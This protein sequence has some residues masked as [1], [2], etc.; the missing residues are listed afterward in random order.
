MVLM[1]DA[2]SHKLML[3]FDT[4][5]RTHNEMSHLVRIILTW[6]ACSHAKIYVRHGSQQ[7]AALVLMWD[8]ISL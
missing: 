7:N 4:G 2:Y 8:A 3:K 1:W 5:S 6:L